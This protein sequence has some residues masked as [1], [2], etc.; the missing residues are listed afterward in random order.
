MIRINQWDSFFFLGKMISISEN[1]ELEPVLVCWTSPSTEEER[2]SSRKCTYN[3]A[4]RETDRR[5]KELLCL[6]VVRMKNNRAATTRPRGRGMVKEGEA[7]RIKAERWRKE[8]RRRWMILR[9]GNCGQM[10]S[11]GFFFFERGGGYCSTN[12]KVRIWE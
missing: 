4:W 5:M 8:N 2:R 12:A 11:L 6:F 1:K 7:R 10:Q 3:I 9:S